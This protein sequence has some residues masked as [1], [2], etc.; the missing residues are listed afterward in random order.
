MWNYSWRNLDVADLIRWL[1]CCLKWCWTYR[2]AKRKWKKNSTNCSMILEKGFVL[3][4]SSWDWGRSRTKIWQRHGKSRANTIEITIFSGGRWRGYT[5]NADGHESNRVGVGESVK[6]DSEG[7][8][9]GYWGEY[10]N[11]EKTIEVAVS[12]I[13]EDMKGS[14]WLEKS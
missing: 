10:G 3:N 12:K 2:H 13:S 1:A 7:D 5:E 6:H 8:E 11:R 9:G 14:N 4:R